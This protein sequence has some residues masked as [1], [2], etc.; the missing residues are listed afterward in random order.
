MIKE[1][2]VIK[3]SLIIVVL[4][5]LTI[6][7]SVCIAA[8]K[9]I[10]EDEIHVNIT[11][12]KEPG[13]NGEIIYKN[14]MNNPILLKVGEDSYVKEEIL[15]GEIY[16]RDYAISS[17]GLIA[18]VSNDSIDLASVENGKE[19]IESWL[20]EEPSWSPDGNKFVYCYDGKLIC[21]DIANKS[22]YILSEGQ[23]VIILLFL[24]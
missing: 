16:S 19:K 5:F 13:V 15:I 17:S 20:S 2:K 21:Y 12:C 14:G 23:T 18:Y 6:I 22:K 24:A 7:N 8:I 1:K 4:L 9:E 11:F 3:L 10:I